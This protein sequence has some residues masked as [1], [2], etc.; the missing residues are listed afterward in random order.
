MKIQNNITEDITLMRDLK[1]AI[2]VVT[3]NRLECL[4]KCLSCLK[5]LSYKDRCII[6]IDNAS[7]DGTL[8]YCKN[9]GEIVY[10]R[11][12][13][14]N[15]GSYGFYY[16]LKCASELDVDLVWGMDDDAYAT[17]DSL[18]E[19]VKIYKNK[20]D[21][22]N[23]ALWSN[24]HSHK[25]NNCPGKVEEIKTWTFVGFM[26]SKSMIQEIGLP[27]NDLFIFFDD[28]EYAKRILKFGHKLYKVH[29]SIIIHEG[30]VKK[31]T[32]SQFFE[33]SLF[34]IIIK[35]QKLPSWKWYYMIRNLF[36][37][38]DN[39]KGWLYAFCFGLKQG[40]RMSCLQPSMLSV[41]AKA[42]KDGILGKTG[43]IMI[44]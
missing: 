4:K 27:K 20:S 17:K 24:S 43:K 23:F 39:T 2:V 7:T 5:D 10:K 32:D 34:G 19:L 9:L 3:Y 18:T 38:Q 31:S 6:V 13:E 8:D 16:G 11:L 12:D 35:L 15:G 26:L 21:L 33:K 28:A 30:A 41:W 37:I 36:V 44:P 1:V 22:S 42:M 40:L 14:N 29:D 25:D